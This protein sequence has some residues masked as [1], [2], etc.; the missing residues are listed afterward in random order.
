M[1][2]ITRLVLFCLMANLWFPLYSQSTESDSRHW[3]ISAGVQYDQSRNTFTYPAPP[4]SSFS[5]GGNFEYVIALPRIKMTYFV[6]LG[7]Q[8][9]R[10]EGYNVAYDNDYGLEETLRVDNLRAGPGFALTL[11]NK[12]WCHPLF[13]VQAFLGV[14]VNTEYGFHNARMDVQYDLPL[15]FS[16]EGGAG[17]Y[18][19]GHFFA[20]L[21]IDVTAKSLLRI[22]AAL[23]DHYQYASWELPSPFEGN[24]KAR[25]VKGGYWQASF[26]VVHHL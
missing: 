18:T 7:F 2:L 1:V 11:N 20:G 24:E 22:K 25:L 21:E 8:Q 16:A 9:I 14:P 15:F 4:A 23:G 5:F 19:G 3:Q 26:E 6:Y 17:V 10:G 12:G 13:G